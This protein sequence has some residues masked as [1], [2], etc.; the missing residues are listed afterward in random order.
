MTLAEQ[1]KCEIP[2]PDAVK[3][4][5]LY[6]STNATNMPDIFTAIGT[7]LGVVVTIMM[8]FYAAGAWRTSREQLRE[9]QDS[10][11]L[12]VLIELRG[13]QAE[14]DSELSDGSEDDGRSERIRAIGERLRA[15][16]EKFKMIWE[17]PYGGVGISDF[18]TC[19]LGAI[20]GANNA[21]YRRHG[22]VGHYRTLRSRGNLIFR[23]F[24]KNKPF[25]IDQLDKKL[26]DCVSSTV[27]EFPEVHQSLFDLYV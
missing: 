10:T 5:V 3:E 22:A 15:V 14:F 12:Q 9:M 1:F 25:D 26:I 20:H 23:D 19:L 17:Y 2:T 27:M 7:C 18:N 16:E 24:Y 8:A 21:E 4:G 13:I 11:R 6:C